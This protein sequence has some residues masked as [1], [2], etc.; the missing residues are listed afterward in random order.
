MS[1]LRE[2]PFN[3]LRA[4][5]CA[6]EC[7]KQ[8]TEIEAFQ[9]QAITKALKRATDECP[10]IPR[11]YFGRKVPNDQCVQQVFTEVAVSVNRAL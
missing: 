6:T 10:S 3:A 7:R 11:G 8:M 1:Y 9:Q 4:K 5:L 2:T